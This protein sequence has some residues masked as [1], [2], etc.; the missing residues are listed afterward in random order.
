MVVK[1]S[2]CGVQMPGVESPAPFSGKL[3][4]SQ[5]LSFFI[6]SMGTIHTH[7]IGSV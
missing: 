4:N 3:L 6:C 7:L 2:G 1:S 5:C